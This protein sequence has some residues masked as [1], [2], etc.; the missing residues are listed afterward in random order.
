MV[1]YSTAQFT[2]SDKDQ[3][4][5]LFRE[6]LGDSGAKS[7]F[8]PPVKLTSAHTNVQAVPVTCGPGGQWTIYAAAVGTSKKIL[9]NCTLTRWAVNFG[10]VTF[11]Q[12]AIY[13]YKTHVNIGP[14]VIKGQE[15][16][17]PPITA[18]VSVDGAWWRT[19]EE[20]SIEI[21][22]YLWISAP[23]VVGS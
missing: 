13:L 17:P 3:H 1:I 9:P 2:R 20:D 16:P 15:S 23:M 5:T 19:T 21:T 11:H 7:G 18:T 12:G 4:I 6:V 8:K 14:Y 10:N 22:V